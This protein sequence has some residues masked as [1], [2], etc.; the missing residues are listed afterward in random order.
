VVAVCGDEWVVM[1]DT[2]DVKPNQ[3]LASDGVTIQHVSWG[4]SGQLRDLV[5]A[6]VNRVVDGDTRPMIVIATQDGETLSGPDKAR[7]RAISEHCG[8]GLAHLHRTMI[9][10]P[11]YIG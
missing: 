11:D 8:I 10:N 9:K 2:V 3:C 4:R 1:P 6:A 5:W 7:H